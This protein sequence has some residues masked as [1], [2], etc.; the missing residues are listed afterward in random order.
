MVLKAIPI[1]LG[2]KEITYPYFETHIVAKC[3]P[4]TCAM[5][6]FRLCNTSLLRNP[7]VHYR[8][9]KCPSF[10][11]ILI[12]I[13]PV[14]VPIPLLEDPF[15]TLPSNLRLGLPSGLFPSGFPTQTLHTPLLSPIRATSPAHLNLLDLTTTIIFGQEYRS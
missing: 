15:L 2:L 7:S 4:S 9:H 13:N 8:A 5:L 10:V 3:S 11:H 14:H 6:P 1:Y 12:Q